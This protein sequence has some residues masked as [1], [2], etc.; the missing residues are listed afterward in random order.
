MV[1]FRI[2]AP[3]P[4]KASRS[5][6]GKL[7]Y[8]LQ[9]QSLFSA[10]IIH[11][12]GNRR[13]G[14]SVCAVRGVNAGKKPLVSVTCYYS[15]VSINFSKKGLIEVVDLIEALDW[16]CKAMRMPRIEDSLTLSTATYR[17]ERREMTEEIEGSPS[18]GSASQKYI[19]GPSVNL[20]TP[21]LPDSDHNCW[22]LLFTPVW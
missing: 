21:P 4:G 9:F 3:G 10:A 17:L 18:S 16:L 22:H 5:K 12:I 8:A 13:T 15:S 2:R 20:N 7:W 1:W 19:L 14:F 11:S 6:S